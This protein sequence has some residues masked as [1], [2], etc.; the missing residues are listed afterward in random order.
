MTRSKN[1]GHGQQKPLVVAPL[2]SLEARV[3]IAV[4]ACVDG[5]LPVANLI[6][7]VRGMIAVELARRR[8]GHLTR[9]DRE[10]EREAERNARN[11]TATEPPPEPPEP[12]VDPTEPPPS[13]RPGR[14][15]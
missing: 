8:N 15:T 7:E 14:T 9:L 2:G 6:A 4:R 1:T 13:Y 11:G 10:A 12:P 5:R 3:M